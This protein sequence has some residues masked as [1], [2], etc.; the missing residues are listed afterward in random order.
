[1]IH[2][3]YDGTNEQEISKLIEE[4]IVVIYEGDT[5][6][7]YL[8]DVP[9]S[10]GNFVLK[11]GE[12]A[13]GVALTPMPPIPMVMWDGEL[14]MVQHIWPDNPAKFVAKIIT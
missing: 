11:N 2:I 6:S 10:K 13:L 9:I 14:R 8:Y 4:P 1:M 5:K 12:D 3:R 7:V